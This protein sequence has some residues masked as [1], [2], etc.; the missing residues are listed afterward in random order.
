M[1]NLHLVEPYRSA[2]VARAFDEGLM[3][4]THP[5]QGIEKE[6]ATLNSGSNE[7]VQ[8]AVL[9]ALIL[10]EDVTVLWRELTENDLEIGKTGFIGKAVGELGIV[11]Y[12]DMPWREYGGAQSI[13]DIWRIEQ[14][15]MDDL[16]PIVT[17]QLALRGKDFHY[18]LLRLVRAHRL[19][20]SAAIPLILSVIPSSLKS[21]IDLILSNDN[22]A[23]HKYDLPL[24]T[25]LHDVRSALSISSKNGGRVLGNPVATDQI[26][27]ETIKDVEAASEVV[28]IVVDTLLRERI[29]FPQPR[30]LA[31]VVSLRARPE[32]NDFRQTFFPWIDAIKMGDESRQKQLRREVINISKYFKRLPHIE[33]FIKITEYVGIPLGILESALGLIGVGATTGLVSIGLGQLAKRLKNK[34]SWMSLST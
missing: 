31:D 24:L 22:F 25:S 21:E 18:G 9:Q 4:L 34:T 8:R 1:A 16:W 33:K 11:R 2:L 12:V 19:G 23:A 26:V 30:S 27:N 3:T 29:P 5:G 10:F 15:D 17:D 32:L 6:S 28:Q 20:D 14:Q 7:R 13:F